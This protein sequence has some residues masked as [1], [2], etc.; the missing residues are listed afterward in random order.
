MVLTNIILSEKTDKN[1]YLL[2][3]KVLK[4]VKLFWSGWLP[5]GIVMGVDMSRE[6]GVL[7]IFCLDPDLGGRYLGSFTLYKNSA[8][9][10]LK[11]CITFFMTYTSI[12]RFSKK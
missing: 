1:K 5:L 12:K 4:Q 3:D 6:S 8:G 10:P 2:F 9:Y 11:I 7:D